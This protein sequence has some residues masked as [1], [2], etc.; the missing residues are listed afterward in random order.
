MQKVII[1]RYPHHTL[2]NLDCKPE[3][4]KEKLSFDRSIGDFCGSI[5]HF[6]TLSVTFAILSITFA[7]LSITLALSVILSPPSTSSTKKSTLP[8]G[9]VVLFL[10]Y[11]TARIKIRS[12]S[13]SGASSVKSDVTST[14]LK[15]IS[16]SQV[17]YC[18]IGN[19][20]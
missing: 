19:V 10:I 1:W 3:R 7:I 4:E 2:T 16:R 15:P 5:R 8:I 6:A 13:Y 17:I 11:F 20:R 12:L 18:S 14:S 9:S